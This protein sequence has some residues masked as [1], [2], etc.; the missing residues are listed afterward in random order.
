MSNGQNVYLRITA[1]LCDISAAVVDADR[2]TV[3]VGNKIAWITGR[4]R[5]D[6]GIEVLTEAP[7]VAA[8]REVLAEQAAA[9]E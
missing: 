2:K 7:L 5:G 1:P 9:Q 6:W 4:S 3:R 8:I